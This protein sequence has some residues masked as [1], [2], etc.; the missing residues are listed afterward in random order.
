M[1]TLITTRR[2]DLLAA[3][4]VANNVLPLFEEE[5]EPDN[6]LDASRLL[7][8]SNSLQSSLDI[9]DILGRFSDEIKQYIPHEFLGYSPDETPSKKDF[10]FSLGKKAR[11]KLNQQLSFSSDRN[12]GSLVISR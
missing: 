1:D 7:H 2:H 5:M 6:F 12:L 10:D 9:D 3:T 11:F 8:L 4:A